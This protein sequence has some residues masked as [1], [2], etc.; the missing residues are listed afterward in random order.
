MTVILS[1][2]EMKRA[3]AEAIASGTP[4]R[5]LMER[6]ARAALELFFAEFDTTN[7]LFLCGNGN[8]GGYAKR[9]RPGKGYCA[10]TYMLCAEYINK[11]SNSNSRS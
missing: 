6:A 1:A 11:G 2:T 5:T 8:N 3:D 7:P 4:S 9:L 10:G